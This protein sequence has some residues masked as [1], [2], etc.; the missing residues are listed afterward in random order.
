MFDFIIFVI[1]FVLHSIDGT[2]IAL[3]SL[4]VALL[5]RIF[6]AVLAKIITIASHWLLML[7]TNALI[8]SVMLQ[9][10]SHNGRMSFT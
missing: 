4:F 2:L 9:K 1:L 6:Q 10:G 3:L 8:E 5:G 7:L